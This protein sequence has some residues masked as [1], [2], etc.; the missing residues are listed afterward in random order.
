MT[1]SR[2]RNCSECNKQLGG[3]VGECFECGGEKPS[4]SREERLA[5]AYLWKAWLGVPHSKIMDAHE[6]D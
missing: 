1:A 5:D 4:P 3:T 6:E 2:L